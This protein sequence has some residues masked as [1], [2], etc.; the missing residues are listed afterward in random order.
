[1]FEPLIIDFEGCVSE[2]LLSAPVLVRGV[3]Q[4]S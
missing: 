4:V 1:M 3:W 2:L